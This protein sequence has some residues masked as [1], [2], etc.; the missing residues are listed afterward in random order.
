MNKQESEYICEKCGEVFIRTSSYSEK[1]HCDCCWKL[2]IAKRAL[3]LRLKNSI[4]KLT[5][6]RIDDPKLYKTIPDEYAK[7]SIL[8]KKFESAIGWE[9]LKN[10][11]IVFKH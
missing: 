6:K 4:E 2:Y 5:G 1:K 8:I 10:K 7:A 11:P 9:Q 3:A